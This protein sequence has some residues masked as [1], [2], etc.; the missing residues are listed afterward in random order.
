MSEW[1]PVDTALDNMGRRGG[2]RLPTKYIVLL[3]ALVLVVTL[4]LALLAPS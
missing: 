1:D 3:V 2:G 4:V